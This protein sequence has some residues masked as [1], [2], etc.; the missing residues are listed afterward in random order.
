MHMHVVYFIYYDS[1]FS[2]IIVVCLCVHVC[3]CDC[4]CC[5]SQFHVKSKFIILCWRNNNNNNSST[6]KKRPQKNTTNHD[7]KQTI[8]TYKSTIK[9]MNT[10]TQSVTQSNS[11]TVSWSYNT[12]SYDCTNMCSYAWTH[13]FFV[14]FCFRE[15]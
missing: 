6:I 1:L 11:K 3:V 15:V 13:Y 10:F 9:T 8:H 14:S 12:Y 4:Y 5:K 2:I 7:S